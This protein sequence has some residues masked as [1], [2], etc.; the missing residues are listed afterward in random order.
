MSSG[1]PTPLSGPDFAAGVPIA[2]LPQGEPVL[3]HAHG[4][5]VILVRRGETVFATGAKCTHYGAPLVRGLVVGETLRCPW[6][7]AC[8]HLGSGEAIGAPALDPIASYEVVRE[9]D[10]VRVGARRPAPAPR[11]PVSSP[12]SIVILGAGAAGAAATEQLRREGYSGPLVLVGDEPP[13]DRP[14][15]SKDYLAGTAKE[16]WLPL[17][18]AEFYRSLDVELVAGDPATALDVAGKEVT[19]ASGRR[20]PFG[21]LLF[22]T[23]AEP[24]RL[25]LPG[26]ER[27]EVHVL[28]TLA[29]SRA[30]IARAEGGRRAVV[31][32]ASFIGLEVAA[33]L[34][35][36]G[37][38]VDVV[39]PEPVPLARVV[40]EEVGR[41]VLGLHEA[42]GVRFHLGRKPAAI[43]EGAVVLDDGARLACDF[44][45][46][47]VGV[48]P[49]LAL[50][51]AAG[52]TIDRGVVVDE[53]L[54]AAPSVWAAG[55]VARYPDPRSGR[56]VR[57]EHW[58]VAERMGQAAARN[59]L[60]AARPYRDVPFFWSRHYDVSLHYVGHAEEWDAIELRGSLDGRDAL[61]AYR[62]GGRVAAVVTVGRARASLQVEAAMECGDETAV[63]DLVQV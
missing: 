29:D 49:R 25:P 31:V 50:A 43:E 1:S 48:R 58:V 14:N 63:A 44:A 28:R 37:I 52:L 32:G 60:G 38:E 27:P 61:V 2:E 23:G 26:A 36:R 41:F 33:S 24:V 34:R 35:N 18:G 46:M 22:A 57:I 20:L 40:G 51:E 55:D 42:K 21:A 19:L 12:P 17:R 6:H 16:E 3:G 53:Q 15:L 39:A 47:G 5:A 59:M 7:H 54:L 62:H 56:P 11:R 10:R 13:V 4:E 45:V 30:I 9:G 8:F